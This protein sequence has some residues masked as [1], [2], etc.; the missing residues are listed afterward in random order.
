MLNPIIITCIGIHIFYIYIFYHITYIS[1]LSIGLIRFCAYYL[2]GI[3]VNDRPQSLWS[4]PNSSFKYLGTPRLF[5]DRADP[6]KSQFKFVML[7]AMNII[8]DMKELNLIEKIV[9]LEATNN[10]YLIPLDI[11]K[12]FKY[13]FV[14]NLASLF[15]H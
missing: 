10:F 13:N 2:P 6:P 3:W 15:T 7:V 11:D 1:I 4:F 14:L 8:Q 9:L 5:L 12:I